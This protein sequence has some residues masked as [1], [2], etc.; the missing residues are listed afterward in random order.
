MGSTFLSLTNSVLRHFGEVELTSSSFSS[1]NGFH[2]VA[3]DAVLDSI[4][5]IQQA[6]QEWP[7][8]YQ[9]GTF[10]LTPTA[11]AGHTQEY[12]FP[13][14]TTSVQSI[15]WESFML[16]RNDVLDPTVAE[17]K[18]DYID[19]DEWLQKYRAGDKNTSLVEASTSR[20]PKYVYRSQ[21]S[22]VGFSPPPDRAYNIAYDWWGYEADLSAHGDT[23]TIPSN[24]DH[25]IR[26]GAFKRCYTHREDPINYNIYSKAFK[27]GIA[28]MK[29]ALITRV[30]TLR[31]NR[32]GNA[33]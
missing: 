31:D 12:A 17:R 28:R 22:K 23:T 9:A 2:A 8:N 24:W 30:R 18:I 27:D 4:R 16:V 5:E 11:T 21:N 32:V 25:V 33:G 15:D 14:G 29:E 13:S 3:K 6:E 19:Y 1:A 7:F 26:A 20:S 10:T